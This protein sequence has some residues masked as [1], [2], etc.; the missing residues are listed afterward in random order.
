MMHLAVDFG[1]QY[2]AVQISPAIEE[3]IQHGD[4]VSLEGN[5]WWG[6]DFSPNDT[7]WEFNAEHQGQIT[8]IDQQM[9]EFHFELDGEEIVILR[10]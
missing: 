6:E 8:I 3:Q 10:N 7:V 1:T 2:L 5:S 4:F 9:R